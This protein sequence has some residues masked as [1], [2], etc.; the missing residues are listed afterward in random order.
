MYIMSENNAIYSDQKWENNFFGG[1]N[2]EMFAWTDTGQNSY[3]VG[4]SRLF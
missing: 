3:I 2:Q 4:N 1:W